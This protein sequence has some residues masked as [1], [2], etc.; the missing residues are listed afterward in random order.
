MGMGPV[1]GLGTRVGMLAV[2]L[3]GKCNQKRSDFRGPVC[4][5]LPNLLR[6]GWFVEWSGVE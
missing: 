3:D 6:G 5:S 1:T 4:V 2:R